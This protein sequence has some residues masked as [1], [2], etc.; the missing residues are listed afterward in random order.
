MHQIWWSTVTVIRSPFFNCNERMQSRASS[1][2]T[3]SVFRWPLSK[4]VRITQGPMNPGTS[5]AMPWKTPSYFSQISGTPWY[6]HILHTYSTVGLSKTVSWIFFCWICILPHCG[7]VVNS[8]QDSHRSIMIIINRTYSFLTRETERKSSLVIKYSLSTF[9]FP[10]W[11]V[12]NVFLYTYDQSFFNFIH[13][14]K[15]FFLWS[16]ERKNPRSKYLLKFL[17]C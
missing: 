11:W 6:P 5:D 1:H 9:G 4:R 7:H 16:E 8:I 14:K 15:I 12:Y 2:S 3:D 17:S 10:S 13:R